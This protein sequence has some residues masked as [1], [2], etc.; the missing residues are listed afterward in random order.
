MLSPVQ[1]EKLGPRCTLDRDASSAGPVRPSESVISPAGERGQEAQGGENPLPG[2]LRKNSSS[3]ALG[4]ASLASGRASWPRAASQNRLER[5]RLSPPA[6]P[7]PQRPHAHGKRRAQ[8]PHPLR[9][10]PLSQDRHQEHHGAEEHPAPQKPQRRWR[11]A[12]STA[13]PRT[14]EA[15]ADRM[16]GTQIR[17]PATRLALV[18]RSM[19]SAPRTRTLDPAP[20]PRDPRRI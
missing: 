20:A 6:H 9:R 10:R 2:S 5:K 12:P 19:E 18:G 3:R 15:E 14:A 1:E 7:A 11:Q 17:W 13:F 4:R 16:L 8:P